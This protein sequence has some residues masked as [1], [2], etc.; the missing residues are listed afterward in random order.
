MLTL[1]AVYRL[2][3]RQTQGLV[4]SLVALLG[5]EIPVPC[6]TT[7]ARRRATLAV[8]WPP[9]AR[10]AGEPLHLVVDSTGLKV[11]GEGE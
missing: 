10:P 3:L 7:V 11:F 5:V 6:Y 8:R 9:R 1:Q 4:Q 2:P